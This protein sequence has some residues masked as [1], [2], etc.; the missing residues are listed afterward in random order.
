MPATARVTASRS[1]LESKM[2]LETSL[3]VGLL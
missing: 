3:P 2:K 1:R